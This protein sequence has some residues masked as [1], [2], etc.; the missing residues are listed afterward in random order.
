M[1]K[2]DLHKALCEILLIGISV[3]CKILPAPVPELPELK[4]LPSVEVQGPARRKEEQNVTDEMGSDI[5]RFG[6]EVASRIDKVIKRK[7][8]ELW[9]DPWTIQGIPLIIPS[10]Q[11]GFNLGLHAILSD[12]RRQDPHKVQ[13][14]GQ[15]LASDRG[16][17]KH[18]IQVDYP[19]LFELYRITTRVSYNRDI[20][21]RYYGVGNETKVDN[22]GLSND[23]PLYQN[24][25]T[26]PAFK[27]QI[28]RQFGKNFQMGPLFGLKWTEIEVPDGSLLKTQNPVGTGGGR[29]HSVGLAFVY[30]TLDFEPYPTTGDFIEL[31]IN[32][33]APW[34]GSSFDFWRTTF[35][36]RRYYPLHPKLIFAHRTLLEVLS[37]NVPFFELGAVGGSDSTIGFGGD[38]FMRG[39]DGNRFIDHIRFVMGFELRW[40]PIVFNFAN[41]DIVIGFVPF[42]DFGKV[43][44]KMFPV[45]TGTLHASTGWGTRI[46]WDKRLVVRTDFAVNQEGTSFYIELGNS[47]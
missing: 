18:F 29:T 23:S 16:R 21:F 24:N 44:S 8:F 28:L 14:L 2:Q 1:P 27:L 42:V 4:K 7:G 26:G 45:L 15:I 25:R 43:W 30:Q 41:Q 20:N 38:R 37:G 22:A 36:Y 17:Y 3:F 19:H 10:P 47:F 9:G 6:E 40:D 32:R 12:I 39:Y 34:T 33:Y 13:I 46:I 35:T 5:K 31:Y 11:T